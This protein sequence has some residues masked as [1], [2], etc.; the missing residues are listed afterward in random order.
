MDIE[1][2]IKAIETDLRQT[3]DELKKILLDIHNYLMETQGHVSNEPEREDPQEE[4]YSDR[5]GP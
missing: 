5:G 4:L 3:K 2:R 1:D